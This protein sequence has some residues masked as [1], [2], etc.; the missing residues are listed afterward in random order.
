MLNST[1]LGPVDETIQSLQRGRAFSFSGQ[2]R[3]HLHNRQYRSH[4]NVRAG[5]LQR[6]CGLSCRARLC[7][8]F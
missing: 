2:R 3:H 8:R 5:T 4:A 1:W 6:I 7:F